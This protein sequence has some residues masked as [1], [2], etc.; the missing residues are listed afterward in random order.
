MRLL[1]R[2]LGD[3]EGGIKVT[4]GKGDRVWSLKD[5]EQCGDHGHFVMVKLT[6]ARGI[7]I[8]LSGPKLKG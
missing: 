3:R 2:V 8:N 7:V 5:E 6:Q 4:K 1:E